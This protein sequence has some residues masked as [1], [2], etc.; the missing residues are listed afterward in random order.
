[1]TN[2]P[3]MDAQLGMDDIVKYDDTV[4]RACMELE[5]AQKANT[6]AAARLKRAKDAKDAIMGALD[7]SPTEAQRWII[8]PESD[9]LPDEPL[10]Y[11]VNTKPPGEPRVVE[12][13]TV[14]PD[15]SMTLIVVNPE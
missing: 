13:Y 10:Q 5:A 15:H 3:N 9:P 12:E 8:R 14:Q 6:G 4:Y 7:L 1:M 2:S 11:A